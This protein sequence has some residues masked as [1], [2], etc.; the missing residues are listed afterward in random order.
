VQ[1]KLEAL[2]LGYARLGAHYPTSCRRRKGGVSGLATVGDFGHGCRSLA[3][4]FSGITL[5][6][7]W[8]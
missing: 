8:S 5:M 2:G 6:G 3:P 7:R 1:D 4:G